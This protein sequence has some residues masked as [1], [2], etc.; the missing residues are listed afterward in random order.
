MKSKADLY[1]SRLTSPKLT[2]SDI[3]I[4]HRTNYAPAMKYPLP[5]IAVDKE[6]FPPVQSNIM[7]AILNGLGVSRNIPTAI[8]HGP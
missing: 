2:A 8:Q 4:F 7:T 6:V 3:R 1:A 5:A